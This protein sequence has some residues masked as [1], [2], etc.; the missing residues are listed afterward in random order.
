[1]TETSV[2]VQNVRDA[3]VLAQKALKE[4]EEGNYTSEEKYLEMFGTTDVVYTLNK[5]EE[6]AQDWSA[7]YSIFE[8][9]LA[10]L[11]M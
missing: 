8:K 11:E 7:V 1:M 4:L 5:G 2:L 10:S 3:E 6:L 9:W